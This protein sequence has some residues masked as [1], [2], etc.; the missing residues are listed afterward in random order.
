MVDFQVRPLPEQDWRAARA[1]FHAALHVAPPDDETWPQYRSRYQPDR[2]FGAYEGATLIGTARS[3]DDELTVPGGAA[4][5]MAAVS[6]VAVRADRIRRGVLSE[7]MGAQLSAL[8]ERQVPVATLRA[9]E[10]TIYRRFGYGVASRGRCI[11]LD[12]RWAVPRADIAPAGE[13]EL[14]ERDDALRRVPE[15]YGGLPRRAG[16]IGRSRYWWAEHQQMVRR[17]TGPVRAVLHHGMSGVDGFAVYSAERDGQGEGEGRALD[18]LDLHWSGPDA[19][20]ALWR[21]LLSV[22][23]VPRITAA[24][25]PLDEP[26]E[27][28]LTDPRACRTTDVVDE[29]W[30]RLVDVPAALAARAYGEG[31]VVLA[32]TDRQLP[33]NTGTYRV[34]E[35]GCLRTDEPAQLALDVAALAELY[36]GDRSVSALATAGVVAVLDPAAPAV[37]DAM[38]AIARAPWCGTD[39]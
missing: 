36:L 14:I 23:L 39:F 3:F 28:L 27:L 9:S 19:F 4:L 35:H 18:V 37:A 10:A 26:V 20:A 6:D 1:L 17:S 24:G 16:M 31:S 12:R 34:G 29:T 11:E 21:F 30:L 22:D 32:V 33:G 8:A 25:R 38:F 5:P 15:I 13:I 7:L 2:G